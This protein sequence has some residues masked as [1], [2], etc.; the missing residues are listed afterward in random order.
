MKGH[1]E[2]R[3]CTLLKRLGP[4]KWLLKSLNPCMTKK[5]KFWRCP[6]TEFFNSLGYF[7]TLS[8]CRNNVR[9]STVSRSR[10]REIRYL[11]FDVC[12]EGV[13]RKSNHAAKKD[14][15]WPKADFYQR[16]KIAF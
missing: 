16:W 5:A 14:G 1:A 3:E 13:E 2:H 9:F 4:K 8:E 12:F 11:G 15:F 10:K 7:L 6:L